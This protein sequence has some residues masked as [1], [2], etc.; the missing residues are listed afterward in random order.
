VSSLRVEQPVDDV[1]VEDWRHVH[2]TIIPTAPL[3]TD[4]VRERLRR[5]RL[6][7]AYR[8]E[9]LVGCTTVRPP[10]GGSSTATVIVRVLPAERRHGY[11]EELYTRS[12]RRART[13]GATTIETIVLAS[14]LDGLRF[15]ATHGFVEESRYVLDGHDIPFVTLRLA[16]P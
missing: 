5:N 6:E 2:N 9:I 8:D 14:N 16:A 10:A 12:L 11:G 13:L 3:S 15:A 1:T 4:E 7:V